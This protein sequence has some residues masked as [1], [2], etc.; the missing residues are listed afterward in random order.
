MSMTVEA[1]YENGILKLIQPLPLDEHERVRVTI[2]RKRNPVQETYGMFGWTG[3]H[4][5]LEYLA[6]DSDL[7][8]HESA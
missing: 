1:T 2:E 8:P 5:T 7:D 4:E 6:S 3:D